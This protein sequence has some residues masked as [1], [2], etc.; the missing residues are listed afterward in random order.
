MYLMENAGR[1][2][3]WTQG[4]AGGLINHG[5]PTKCSPTAINGKYGSN[6]GGCWACWAARGVCV[7]G[8][9]YCGM[10]VPCKVDV[11]DQ[12]DP[13]LLPQLHQRI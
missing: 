9:S 4:G 12:R 11:Q 6:P 1:P 5:V 2:N 3:W 7:C 10:S 13:R 8:S